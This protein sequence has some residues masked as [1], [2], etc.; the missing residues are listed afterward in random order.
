MAGEEL[1]FL[2]QMSEQ[3]LLKTLLKNDKIKGTFTNFR[4]LINKSG[5]C[6]GEE[7]KIAFL[8]QKILLNKIKKIQP[9]HSI[10]KPQLK[11]RIDYF[12]SNL[13]L[14]NF[15]KSVPVGQDTSYSKWF[16]TIF[17]VTFAGWRQDML[18]KRSNTSQCLQTIGEEKQ[19]DKCYLCGRKLIGPDIKPRHCEHVLPIISA[20]GHLWLTFDK[21]SEYTEEQVNTLKK[22]YAWAHECCNLIKSNREFI[23]VSSSKTKYVI[24]TNELKEFYSDIEESHSYDCTPINKVPVVAQIKKDVMT[25]LIDIINIVNENINKLGGLDTYHLFFKLKILSAFTN[26]NFLKALTGDGEASGPEEE[27]RI[28]PEERKASRDNNLALQK[29]IDDSEKIH[30]LIKPKISGIKRELRSTG[31]Y[32]E[33]KFKERLNELYKRYNITLPPDDIYKTIQYG[34]VYTPE[35]GQNDAGGGGGAVHPCDRGGK[36]CYPFNVLTFPK[37]FLRLI[38]MPEEEIAGGISSLKKFNDLLFM[39]ILETDYNPSIQQDI[40]DVKVSIVNGGENF[41]QRL[42][43]HVWQGLNYKPNSAAVKESKLEKG[44]IATKVSK[45]LRTRKN[46]EKQLFKKFGLK[47]LGAKIF[48]EM[49]K[50]QSKARSKKAYVRP[51]SSSKM[52]SYSQTRSK[53]NMQKQAL[54]AVLKDFLKKKLMP[55]MHEKKVLTAISKEN[56][57]EMN[58]LGTP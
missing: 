48:S 29:V 34:G 49:K 46:I 15:V 47:E 21:I 42:S 53:R 4:N 36:D 31:N 2:N 11:A 10:T 20:I 58:L 55:K 16:N 57:D 17:G 39:H 19:E 12:K 45:S 40:D 27:V 14:N 32:T 37:R 50:Q 9:T 33:E 7:K 22:E 44:Q 38:G 52:V 41:R 51:R 6:G 43:T 56:K 18:I 13:F 25:R 54:N 5:N 1:P 8:I 3:S 23:K 28:T 35:N 24:D 30:N 26:E